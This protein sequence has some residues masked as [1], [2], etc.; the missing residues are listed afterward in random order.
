MGKNTTT[1]DLDTIDRST[2]EGRRAWFAAFIDRNM[3]HNYIEAKILK[4]IVKAFK[5]AGNPIVKIDDREEVTEVTDLRS[6]QEVVFNLD[7][8][9]LIPQNGGWIRFILGN[10]WDAVSDYTLNY[11]LEETMSPVEAWI[12]KHQD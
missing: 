1:I 4:R 7:E 10:E 3:A 5:E 8:C 9:W 11:G 12:E 6:I 2:E